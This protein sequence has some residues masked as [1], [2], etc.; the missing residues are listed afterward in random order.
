MKRE[1]SDHSEEKARRESVCMCVC[2][3]KGER[4]GKRERVCVCE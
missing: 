3:S 4:E 2:V 1:V